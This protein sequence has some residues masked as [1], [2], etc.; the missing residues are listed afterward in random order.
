MRYTYKLAYYWEG[1]KIPSFT[2]YDKIIIYSSN[3]EITDGIVEQK[4]DLYKYIRYNC[5]IR[6]NVNVLLDDT[7]SIYDTR[8]RRLKIKVLN[9]IENFFIENKYIS[10]NLFLYINRMND[11]LLICKNNKKL[12]LK[13]NTLVDFKS[14]VSYIK[15]TVI[16]LYG[17]DLEI[18]IYLLRVVKELNKLITEKEFQLLQEIKSDY[19]KIAVDIYFQLLNFISDLLFKYLNYSV[20]CKIKTFQTYIYVLNAIIKNLL[21]V[22]QPKYNDEEIISKLTVHIHKNRIREIL[23]EIDDRFEITGRKLK[24]IELAVICLI[25]KENCTLFS[26]MDFKT[27]QMLICQYYTIEPT[28]YKMNDCRGNTYNK[29]LNENEMFFKQILRKNG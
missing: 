10:S 16:S 28:T 26:E 19:A 21:S 6:Y 11:I 7:N 5:S 25:L 27:F 2:N 22:E 17:N 4:T 3:D 8:I 9:K 1:E 20:S 12:D 29:I 15:D 13:I 23:N 24:K 18:A 14:T